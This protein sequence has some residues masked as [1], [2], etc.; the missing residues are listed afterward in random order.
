MVKVAVVP[1]QFVRSLGELVTA[2]GEQLA[3]AVTSKDVL[4]E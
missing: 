3:V 2:G 1:T 4:S